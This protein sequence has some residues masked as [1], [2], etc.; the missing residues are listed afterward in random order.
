VRKLHRETFGAVLALAMVACSVACVRPLP[1]VG[2]DASGGSG[3]STSAGGDTSA[4]GSQTKCQQACANLRRL[5]CSDASELCEQQCSM[6]LGDVR[7]VFDVQCRIDAE[8][9]G[10]AQACGIASCK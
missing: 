8:T 5:G 6:M 3:G 2:P 10:Q 4:G 7:F 1:P 9:K